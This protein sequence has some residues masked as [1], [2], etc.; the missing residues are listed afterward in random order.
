VDDVAFESKLNSA[1]EYEELRDEADSLLSS[2][3]HQ[4]M[5]AEV[6]SAWG[7]APAVPRL[8][9]KP[10]YEKHGEERVADGRYHS[11]IRY[12]EHVAPFLRALIASV[13][14]SFANPQIEARS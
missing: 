14:A 4:G 5:R 3:G 12:E 1:F 6:L 11:V 8:S 7:A 9:E 10:W 13:H 2:H